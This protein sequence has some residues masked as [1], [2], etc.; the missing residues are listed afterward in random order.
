MS[1]AGCE[2]VCLVGRLVVKL[3][4]W[5]VDWSCGCLGGRAVS[6]NSEAG[7]EAVSLVG[8]LAVGLS[9]W[10]IVGWW[11]DGLMVE[12]SAWM[13]RGCLFGW[14][15]GGQAVTLDGWLVLWLSGC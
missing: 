5:M 14:S 11:A 7:R 1:L 3:S 6:L 12:L 15:V 9:A 10:V 4:P 8:W 2:A 13:A